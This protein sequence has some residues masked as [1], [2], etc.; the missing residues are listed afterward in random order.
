MTA[1]VLERASIAQ[2]TSVLDVGCGAGQTLRLVAGLNEAALLIGVDPDED[3]C[4]SGRR[5]GERIHF[6][7]GEGE[8]LPLADGS[9][10]HVICR[11]AVNY[12]HQARALREMTRVLAPGGTLVLSFIGFG[13]SLREVLAPGN[14]GLRQRLG[15]LKC[16]LSGILLQT[17]GYQGERGTFW[18]RSVPYTSVARLQCQLRER[19][20]TMTWLG[21]EG[22]FLGTATICW[23]IISKNDNG[24]GVKQ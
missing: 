5:G 23:A 24:C 13:Y 2:A 4:R 19:G 18:G 16:L 11:V 8:R 12:M 15:N 20:C 22:R 10:T 7:K 6:L 9:V 21:C 14:A 17:L 3:A 1:S